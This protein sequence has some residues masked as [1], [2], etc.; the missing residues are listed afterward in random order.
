MKYIT[1]MIA[2]AILTLIPLLGFSAATYAQFDPLDK[3][4]ENAVNRGDAQTICDA[5]KNPD[6]PI[7]GDN[8]VIDNVVNILAIAAS[9]IAV[10][11]IIIAGITMMTANGD[12]G[13]IATSSSAIIYTIVGLIVII[14]AR[15]IVVF[16]LTKVTTG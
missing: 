8:S 15:T 5:S 3:T 11:V 7:T 9:V 10:I 4:C 12:A 16:V 13:K 14:V 1:R 2:I 6:N